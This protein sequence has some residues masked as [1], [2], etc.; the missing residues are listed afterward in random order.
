MLDS[1]GAA[2]DKQFAGSRRGDYE[3]AQALTTDS[4]SESFYARVKPPK[5][6]VR[7]VV[8]ESV[9]AATCDRAGGAASVLAVGRRAALVKSFNVVPVIDVRDEDGIIAVGEAVDG[10]TFAELLDAMRCASEKLPV[11]AALR[12]VVDT[13]AG[14][15]AAHLT[16][17]DAVVHGGLTTNAMV[18]VGDGTTKVAD[19]ALGR[20]R[21]ASARAAYTRDAEAVG[22]PSVSG[23]VFAAGVIAWEAI[24]GKRLFAGDAPCVTDRA[25]E[26]PAAGTLVEGVP[27]KLDA[28]I[29]KALAREPS[30][31]FASAAEFARAM[32]TS[33][34]R[35]AMR[36]AVGALLAKWV[37]NTLTQRRET[38]RRLRTP[39]P[40]VSTAHAGVPGSRVDAVLKTPSSGGHAVSSGLPERS[41]GQLP[42]PVRSMA[43][44]QVAK[45]GVIRAGGGGTMPGIQAPPASTSDAFDDLMASG[46]SPSPH[47]DV[48]PAPASDPGVPSGAVV[49]ASGATGIAV[50]APSAAV[51]VG[52][53]TGSPDTT[54]PLDA[55]DLTSVPPG[56]SSPVRSPAPPRTPSVQRSPDTTMPLAAAEITEVTSLEPAAPPTVVHAAPPV[57]TETSARTEGTASSDVPVSDD[58]DIPIDSGPLSEDANEV[59]PAVVV[60]VASPSDASAH[61]ATATP[62]IDAHDATVAAAATP[63]SAVQ[64]VPAEV[65]EP[66]A[67]DEPAAP[68]VVAPPNVAPAESSVALAA[69]G[70][71]DEPLVLPTHSRT[72]LYAALGVVALVVIGGIALAFRGGSGS[73]PPAR[74]TEAV[75]AARPA[76]TPTVVDRPAALHD[77]IT[78]AAPN[79]DTTRPA[80]NLPAS[81]HRATQPALSAPAPAHAHPS[82]P[83]VSRTVV[84]ANARAAPAVPAARVAHPV[85]RASTRVAPVTPHS[86]TTRTTPVPAHRHEFRPGGL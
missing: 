61:A 36:S 44:P 57:S 73:E 56:E 29:A 39:A 1:T 41:P 26:I 40:V 70:L 66:P 53:A 71:D 2:P 55:L 81:T 72:T 43:A 23:D 49:A 30:A 15:H 12:V 18:I 69:V 54:M 24:T 68:R 85:N 22:E 79:A 11:E 6:M 25:G 65:V 13:L 74:H 16:K 14:L 35:V 64:S 84:P 27:A 46:N 76:P 31:G 67:L 17:P 8:L 3:L 42:H 80:D 32:E 51:R 20:W 38:I 58:F 47:H 37:K 19:F 83:A 82:S 62:P 63:S 50:I 45:P 48:T 78:V 5:G 77:T 75:P 86:A 60:S 34:A 33:G 9:S 59:A 21:E 52:R 7:V 10:A 28:A 4:A